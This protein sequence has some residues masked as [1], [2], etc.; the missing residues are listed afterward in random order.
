MALLPVNPAKRVPLYPQS[1]SSLSRGSAD[2]E[3]YTSALH[4]TLITQSTRMALDDCMEKVNGSFSD[5]TPYAIVEI[6]ANFKVSRSLGIGVVNGTFS[7][8]SPSFVYRHAP[9]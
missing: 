4:M 3:L 6:N 1:A 5:P 8:R 9:T 7:T 2:A